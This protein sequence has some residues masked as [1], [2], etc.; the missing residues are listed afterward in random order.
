M[1]LR[2]HDMKNITSIK[3]TSTLSMNT[4]LDAQFFVNKTDGTQELAVDIDFQDLFFN[5]NA[6][7]ENMALKP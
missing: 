1:K 5:F 2:P 6:T 4:D 7:V 3:D